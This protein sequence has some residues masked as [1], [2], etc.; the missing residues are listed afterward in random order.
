MK[1]LG[2]SFGGTKIVGMFGIVEELY[3]QGYH[4]N[5]ISGISTGAILALPL[6]LGKLNEIKEV[7]VDLD[8]DTFMN[9]NPFT[10]RNN[11]KLSA[12]YS[13][14]VNGYLGEQENIITILKS[15]I[16]KKEFRAWKFND[17]RVEVYVQSVNIYNGSRKVSKLSELN[18]EDCFKEIMASCSIPLYVDGVYEFNSLY[19][20]GGLRNFILT[21]YILKNVEGITENVSIYSRPEDYKII[22]S[23]IKG[24]LP[25]LNR[26]ID[27]FLV[28][29][30]KRDELEEERIVVE[31]NINSKIYY[32]PRILTSVYDVDD[33]KL[34][35]LY[36]EGIDI[37]KKNLFRKVN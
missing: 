6:A 18:Y 16:T 22:D 34:K 28:E 1:H 35:K 14:L 31:N 17:N 12:I 10:K 13:L 20:D 21:P 23:K 36:L 2:L 29:I 19:F 7:L 3:N 8:H 33:Y 30:S 37:V 15:I 25:M 24:V 9:K 26:I 4:P 5:I 27:I 32:L 11:I